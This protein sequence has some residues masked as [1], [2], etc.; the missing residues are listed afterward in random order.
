MG[1]LSWLIRCCTKLPRSWRRA[2]FLAVC[3]GH[4]VNRHGHLFGKSGHMER[5]TIHHLG[6][7]AGNQVF[8]CQTGM[9]AG[10]LP[11]LASGL[12]PIGEGQSEFLYRLGGP[13]VNPHPGL[14]QS[15]IIARSSWMPW[16]IPLAAA[17]SAQPRSISKSIWPAAK[18][19]LRLASRTLSRLCASP[20]S[21][22][23]ASG[24]EPPRFLLASLGIVA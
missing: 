24:P 17:P 3:K 1:L 15:C 2:P 16:V 21:I 9:I 8:R 19:K 20:A 6:G 12:I 11:Q 22:G 5:E 23:F 13:V 7:L 18:F 10:P 4:L 14:A